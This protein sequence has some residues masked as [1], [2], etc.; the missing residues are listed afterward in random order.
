MKE[1]VGRG[2]APRQRWMPWGSRDPLAGVLRVNEILA[3][4]DGSEVCVR[5]RVHAVP[6]DYD[7]RLSPA[8]S[9]DVALRRYYE[10]LADRTIRIV[11]PDPAGRPHRD[12]WDAGL[13][14]QQLRRTNRFA[15][16]CTDCEVI[17]LTKLSDEEHLETCMRP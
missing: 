10:V 2:L 6:Q 16:C 11:V 15:D 3:F 5:P 17:S 4:P 9:R 1:A 12:I 13:R 7:W 8:W 14:L